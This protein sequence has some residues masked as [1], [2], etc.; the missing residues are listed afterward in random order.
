MLEK[1]THMNRDQPLFNATTYQGQLFGSG[2]FRPA[3]GPAVE[4]V[5]KATG[6]T[7]YTAG[8][9]DARDVDAAVEA[10]VRA[11]NGVGDDRPHGARRYRSPLLQ[12]AGAP[13]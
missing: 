10:A 7:L 13:S 1:T 9:A 5:E 3:R 8:L 12:S 2:G 6:E 4:V 11:Q